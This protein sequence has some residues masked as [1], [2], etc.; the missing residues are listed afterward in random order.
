M[1]EV[2]KLHETLVV[3]WSDEYKHLA[4]NH[5]DEANEHLEG[6]LW[7]TNDVGELEE[8]GE[9]RDLFLMSLKVLTGNPATLVEVTDVRCAFETAVCNFRNVQEAVDNYS[10]CAG[11]CR[12]ISPCARYEY[13]DVL[14]ENHT[15]AVDDVNKTYSKYVELMFDEANRMTKNVGERV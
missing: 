13:G 2:K 10:S 12:C 8:E 9:W 3:G 15:E 1:S 5:F 4:L 11:G 6:E 14:A 7:F